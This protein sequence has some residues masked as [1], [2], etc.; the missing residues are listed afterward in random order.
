MKV[1]AWKTVEVECEVDVELEDMLNEFAQRVDES[2]QD[3]W[4]RML[5]AMDR[6]TRIME[7]ISDETIDAV[8]SEHRWVIKQRLQE[9]CERW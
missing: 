4:R 3:Y 1:T 7:R 2:S 8:K 6:M 9:Q 5:P